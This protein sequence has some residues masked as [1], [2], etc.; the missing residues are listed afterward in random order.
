[1]RTADFDV[2]VIG[3]GAGGG[4]AAWTFAKAGK[5]VLVLE[6][7]EA[8]PQGWTGR[9]LLRN[10]RYSPYGHNTGPEPEGNP[11]VFV[12]V[13]GAERIVKPYQGGYNNNAMAV[14]G[15][16]RVF[17]AQAW[18][19]HPDDFRMASRYGV[20]SGSSLADWPIGYDHLE[21]YYEQIE[22]ELGVCGGPPAANMPLRRGYP[23]PELPILARGTRLKNA[24]EANGWANQCVPLMINSVPRGGRG[25]C[26]RCEFCV[27]FG[28]PTEAKGG[29]H[30]TVLPKV[31]ATPGCEVRHGMRVTKL[32]T[33]S[34]GNVTGVE[35]ILDREREEIRADIVVLAAGAIE[36]ARLLLLSCTSREPNGI[37]NNDDWVGRNLQG[38]YYPAAQGVFDE[39]IN[40]SLGPGPSIAITEFNHGNEGV[41]GG[42]MLADD[43]IVLP[44]SFASGRRKPGIPNFG[45]EF[46][47][48]VR[49]GYRHSFHI[50]GPVQ[51]IPNPD[52]R[53][54]LDPDVVDDLGVPVVRLSGTTHP[55]TVKTALFIR[56]RAKD[57]LNAAG[58]REVWTY[59]V[60]LSL[61]GGQHQ[62]G[63]CRMATAPEQGVVDSAGR[64]FGHENLLIC[65]GSV[66]VTNGGFN[67]FLT[68]MATAMRSA[69]LSL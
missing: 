2:I 54:T 34:T 55:E 68:I 69:E 41:I 20:P 31:A 14:G 29:A 9:D 63:T 35:A 48:W 26:V 53:V 49:Y 36:T 62:A 46:K 38:H 19:F 59:P 22:H 66:H 52:G 33:D 27:G 51:E 45:A 5:R 28:C 50:A 6:R 23:M 42:A 13:K 21:P 44:T 43:F 16:T 58:A 30:N 4:V 8:Y 40:E 25:A 15:G 47:D 12:D 32:T 57:W 10:H 56:E 11:R 60:P 17:G 7:G 3:S 18:R 65:D 24:A 1:M 39:P 64:V 67:P 37:G 61:S